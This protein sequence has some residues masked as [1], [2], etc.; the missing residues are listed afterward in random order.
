MVCTSGC[1][2][3][4]FSESK[5]KRFPLTVFLFVL[6]LA[7]WARVLQ[8]WTLPNLAPLP[9]DKACQAAWFIEKAIRLCVCLCWQQLSVS[10]WLK[11]RWWI[12]V[13]L[14]WAFWT[15]TSSNTPPRRC[16]QWAQNVGLLAKRLKLFPG[17]LIGWL[18]TLWR[19]L[20]DS[21]ITPERH[22]ESLWCP[23]MYLFFCLTVSGHVVDLQ[24]PH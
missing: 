22:G 19:T 6:L 8:D 5:G 23:H 16:R 4:F 24:R 1:L 9:A 10:S 2:Q 20:E 3:P 11:V 17:I 7:W 14:R 12:S 21:L 18:E 13:F 15:G